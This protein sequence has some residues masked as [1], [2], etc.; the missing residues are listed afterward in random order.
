[1]KLAL[2]TACAVF[3][4]SLA[5]AA[6]ADSRITATLESAQSGHAKFIAASAVWNCEAGTCVAGLAPDAAATV[7]ACK[8]LA[9]H[10]GRLTAYVSDR[11]ALDAGALAKCNT[12]AAA[13]ASIG[14][15]S[16]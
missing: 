9:K 6:S 10:V 4:L 16:R 1:M 14:T 2:A 13:P 11:R 15:A 5:G 7:G 3:S 8:D 12:A